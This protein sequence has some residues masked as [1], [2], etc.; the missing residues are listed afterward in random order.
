[1]WYATDSDQGREQEAD[2]GAGEEPDQDRKEEGQDVRGE[3]AR[4]DVHAAR[5]VLRVAR[6]TVA[7]TGGRVSSLSVVAPDRRNQPKES[8][9]DRAQTED[10]IAQLPSDG[11]A[12][13]VA[14]GH[15]TVSAPSSQH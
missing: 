7:L 8:S 5:D 13:S 12:L 11:A 15:K 6:A 10:E 3:C 2:D 1:V 4:N 14:H 9:S